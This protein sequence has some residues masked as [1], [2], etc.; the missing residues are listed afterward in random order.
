MEGKKVIKSFLD[1]DVYQRLFALMTVIITKVVT[2][3]PKEE[4]YDLVSQMRRASKAP[5]ALLAEGFAKR[6]QKRQWAKYL[7]D[8]VGECY[9]MMNHL[10]TVKSVYPTY[11]KPESCQELINKYEICC[12]QLTRLK[13]SWTNYHEK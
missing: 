10:D 4:K 6:H 9:E 5:T 8:C 1:L 2:R 7:D 3:L 11:C 12:K 13:Q